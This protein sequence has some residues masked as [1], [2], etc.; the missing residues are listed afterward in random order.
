M[1]PPLLDHTSRYVCV[2]YRRKHYWQ[3]GGVR[4]AWISRASARDYPTGS[5]LTVGL[6]VFPPPPSLTP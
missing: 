3:G 6:M 5:V 4:V 2:L 1:T